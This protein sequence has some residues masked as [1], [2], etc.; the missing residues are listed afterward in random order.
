MKGCFV[1]LNAIIYSRVST[2]EQVGNYSL[3]TQLQLCSTYCD[4]NHWE[5]VQ[6]FTEQGASGRTAER[7]ELQRALKFIRDNKGRVQFFVVASI[8]RFFR[9]T[10]EHLEVR[11][12][13]QKLGVMLRTSA[14]N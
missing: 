9:D 1:M 12:K 10:K 3:S 2:R 14:W 4:Q 7:P 5:I 11:D 13:L 8:D 6:T